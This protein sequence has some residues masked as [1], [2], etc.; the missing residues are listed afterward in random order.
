MKTWA[1]RGT[2]HLL[3]TDELGL[4]LAGLGTYDHYLKP[5]WFRGFGITAEQLEQVIDAVS[6]ALDG[7]QLTREELAAAIADRW[8]AEL[9]QRV[10]ESWGS[11]PQAGG[12]PGAAVLRALRRPEGPLHAPGRLAGPPGGRSRT[13][14]RRCARSPAA[15]SA[16]TAP[17]RATTSP[18]GG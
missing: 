8:L 15:T 9:A 5:G 7:A 3:P 10:G 16:C 18:A 12:V 11:L 13:A 1:M 14:T 17:P 2:L 4:W 6:A